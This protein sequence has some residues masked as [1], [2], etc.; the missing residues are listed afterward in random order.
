MTERNAKDHRCR[1][2]ADNPRCPEQENGPKGLLAA[3]GPWAEFP[4]LDELVDDIYRQR[5]VAQDRQVDDL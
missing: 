2:P 5:G 3:V 1:A 4:E